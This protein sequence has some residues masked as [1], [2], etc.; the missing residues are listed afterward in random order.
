LRGEVL[1]AGVGVDRHGQVFA[2]ALA[3]RG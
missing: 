1:D 2:A 3:E